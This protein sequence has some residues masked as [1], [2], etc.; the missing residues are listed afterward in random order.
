MYQTRIQTATVE[1]PGVE[2]FYFTLEKR[3]I[4]DLQCKITPG[5][6]VTT[7]DFDDGAIYNWFEN[8]DVER[9]EVNGT[10]TTWWAA[11]TRSE[12]I[13]Q[14]PYKEMYCRFYANGSITLKAK[15]NSY[16]WGPLI[17][18][19]PQKGIYHITS[20]KCNDCYND[21]LSDISEDY[22]MSD[23]YY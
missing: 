21:Y 11:P 3:P 22:Y 18:G 7:T 13:N 17:P 4:S 20:C 12:V 8:G 2:G 6:V 10:K 9:I 16:Y 5:T 1:I 15:G 14:N 23:S 19:Y